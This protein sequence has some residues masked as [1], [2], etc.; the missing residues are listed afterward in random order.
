MKQEKKAEK[1]KEDADKLRA[2]E[3]SAKYQAE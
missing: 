2:L 1:K 3:M